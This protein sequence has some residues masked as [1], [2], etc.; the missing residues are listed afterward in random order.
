MNCR[1]PHAALPVAPPPK[2]WHTHRVAGA[3][4]PGVRAALRAAAASDAPLDRAAG[5]V[6]GMAVGDAVGAPLEFIPVHM[7]ALG[8]VD[9]YEGR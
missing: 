2:I 8:G 1:N 3:V 5:A 7:C 4:P 9:S 6:V